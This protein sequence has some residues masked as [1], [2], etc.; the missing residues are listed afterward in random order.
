MNAIQ[1]KKQQIYPNKIVCIGRNYT[2]HI[3]ELKNELPDEIVIFNKPNSSISEKIK[4]FDEFCQFETE[5]AF[6]INGNGGFKGIGI[7]LDLT[8]RNLQ[9][10]L[11]SKG[12]PWERAK[13]FDGSAV[14][15]PFIEIDFPLESVEF[16]LTVNGILRQRGS[17]D[18]MINKPFQIVDSIIKFMSLCE[19]DVIMTGTPDGVSSYAKGDFFQVNLIVENKTKLTQDWTVK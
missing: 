2:S 19:N 7:G 14:F 18:N 16:T 10:E 6:L 12:L 1:F 4:Y 3:L 13:S 9:D 15:S 5:L 8:K 17:F 11:K